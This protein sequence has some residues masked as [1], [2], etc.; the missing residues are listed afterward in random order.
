MSYMSPWRARS[1]FCNTVK[2]RRDVE[3]ALKRNERGGRHSW[4]LAYHNALSLDTWYDISI[5]ICLD[6]VQAAS[7]E[8]EVLPKVVFEGVMVDNS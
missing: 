2:T 8:P 6:C 1:G 3:N 7:S 4:V 5:S